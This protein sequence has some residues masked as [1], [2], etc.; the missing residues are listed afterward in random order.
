VKGLA[1]L[2]SDPSDANPSEIIPLVSNI[3]DARVTI[4]PLKNS[5]PTL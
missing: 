4:D 3:F 1:I 5:M 2:E